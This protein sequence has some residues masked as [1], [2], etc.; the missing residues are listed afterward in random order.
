[1]HTQGTFQGCTNQFILGLLGC[2]QG[3]TP[4][5]NVALSVLIVT[6]VIRVDYRFLLLIVLLWDLD[7]LL[8]INW[9]SVCRGC[10]S[11]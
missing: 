6:V 11:F 10:P 8:I 2:V 3:L 9:L 4:T 1:M 7:W 5:S